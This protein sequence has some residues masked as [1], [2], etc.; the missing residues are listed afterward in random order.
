[1]GVLTRRACKGQNPGLPAPSPT[2]RL[3]N[4]WHSLLTTVDGKKKKNQW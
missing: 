4:Y 3:D 2:Y 1:M